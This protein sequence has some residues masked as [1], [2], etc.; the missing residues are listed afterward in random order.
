MAKTKTGETTST[1]TLVRDLPQRFGRFHAEVWEK[2]EEWLKR[3]GSKIQPFMDRLIDD[4]LAGHYI[5]LHQLRPE[6]ILELERS[7]EEQGTT[8]EMLVSKILSEYAMG[9]MNER[10]KTPKTAGSR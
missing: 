2:F 3:R 8:V 7:A 5:N 10:K 9:K 6:T 4:V 1:Q